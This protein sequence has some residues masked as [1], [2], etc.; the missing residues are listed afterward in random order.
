MDST[1]N[2]IESEKQNGC[3]DGLHSHDRMADWELGLMATTQP[4]ER[5]MYLKKAQNSKFKEW[6]LLN[7]YLLCT[8]IKLK[9]ILS[10]TIL[11]QGPSVV[12]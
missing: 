11:S 4:H 2:C 8:I 6:F 7:M 10:Q 3:I 1:E 12:R 5:V 9:E